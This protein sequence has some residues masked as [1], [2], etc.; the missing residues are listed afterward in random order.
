M[1]D[2]GG[3][4]LHHCCATQRNKQRGEDSQLGVVCGIL[5]LLGEGVGITAHTGADRIHAIHG[6][7]L[8]ASF[9]NEINGRSN[10]E[11]LVQVLKVL[12]HVGAL[13][14]KEVLV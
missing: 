14:P 12:E 4:A 3:K 7:E 9:C 6:G 11:V 5:D 1:K 10:L 2:K 8:E 13:Q